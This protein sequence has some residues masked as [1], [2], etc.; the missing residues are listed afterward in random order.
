ML[1]LVIRQFPAFSTQPLT[2]GSLG[3]YLWLIGGRKDKIIP[4]PGQATGEMGDSL[5]QFY[6]S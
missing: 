2:I 6:V 5:V 1:T 3:A 4:G